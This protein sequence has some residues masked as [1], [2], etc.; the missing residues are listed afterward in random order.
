MAMK[1]DLDFLKTSLPLLESDLKEQYSRLTSVFK[2]IISAK[3]ENEA[4]F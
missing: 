3:T 1:I 2:E 4:F